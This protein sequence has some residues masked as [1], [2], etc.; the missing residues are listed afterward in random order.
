MRP[1][2]YYIVRAKFLGRREVAWQSQGWWYRFGSQ[3]AFCRATERQEE[4][5]FYS[6]GRRVL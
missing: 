2:G 1:D 3:G 4:E 6:I 5:F